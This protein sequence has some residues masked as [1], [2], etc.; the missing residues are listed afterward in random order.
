MDSSPL[1]PEPTGALPSAALIA[2]AMWATKQLRD[3]LARTGETESTAARF[4]L[5]VLG[6]VG[7]R[8]TDVVPNGTSPVAFETAYVAITHRFLEQV[9]PGESDLARMPA[10]RIAEY[11]AA[12]LAQPADP[13]MLTA[14]FG[15]ARPDR[16][17]HDVRLKYRVGGYRGSP[18]HPLADFL[19]EVVIRP[20]V[21]PGP[22]TS[23]R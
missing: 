10:E 17:G 5:S 16:F 9:L 1:V 7:L 4:G 21:T 19:I 12:A 2:D 14:A 23:A 22:V 18:G 8:P 15:S 13:G 20:V 11:V 6:V 3:R